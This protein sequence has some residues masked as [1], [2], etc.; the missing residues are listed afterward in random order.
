VTRYSIAFVLLFACGKS[1]SGKVE[2]EAVALGDT[3]YVVDVPK[4]WTVE[5]PMSG[6]FE[7]KGGRPH[8]QIMTAPA[9]PS[10]LDE[11]VKSTCEGRGEIHKEQLAG[12]GVFVS[13]KGES[14]MVKGVTTT[15]FV[16]EVPKG[17]KASFDC[18]LETDQDPAPAIAICKSIRKK[19]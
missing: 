6:F 2:L 16:V 10:A 18:H 13:C 8:P 3:G 12:G 11:L 9:P 7:L 4:G 5:V 17:D 19:S 1:S 15:T 14:K